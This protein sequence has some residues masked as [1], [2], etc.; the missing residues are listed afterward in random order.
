MRTIS[1]GLTMVWLALIG[2]VFVL[3]LP[4]MRDKTAWQGATVDWSPTATT[5]AVGGAASWDVQGWM[6]DAER[7][8]HDALNRIEHRL[9]V[10]LVEIRE[11]VYEWS[12]GYAQT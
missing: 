10:G 12:E 6:D 8:L 5:K 7:E 9:W 4:P 3:P 1:R 11:N 2:V